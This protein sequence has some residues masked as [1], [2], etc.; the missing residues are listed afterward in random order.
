MNVT[1][2]HCNDALILSLAGRL[3]SN[4]S[5]HFS[6]QLTEKLNAGY[7]KIIIEMDQLEYISSAGLRVL[8]MGAKHLMAIKGQFILCDMN[9]HIKEVFEIS[10]FLNILTIANNLKAAKKII[11]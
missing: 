11:T 6:T 2:D 8:L 5:E 10:G 1:E 9:A 3:D 7:T 4:T